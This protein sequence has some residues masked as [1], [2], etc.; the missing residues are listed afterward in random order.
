MK[1]HNSSKERN[2][3][4]EFKSYFIRLKRKLKLDSSLEEVIW[5]HLRAMGFDHKDKFDEGIKHFGYKI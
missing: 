5:L 2:N 4:K 1:K 3:R